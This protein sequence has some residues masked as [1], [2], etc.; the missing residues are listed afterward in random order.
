MIQNYL[1]L[2]NSLK[3]SK[4]SI[5]LVDKLHRYNSVILGALIKM[6]NRV[7]MFLTVK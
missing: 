4:L 3:L 1:N 2:E 7:L 5:W 6:V